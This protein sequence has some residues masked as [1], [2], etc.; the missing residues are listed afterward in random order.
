MKNKKK[1]NSQNSHR[2]WVLMI[3][4]PPF[5][6]YARRSK[7]AQIVVAFIIFSPTFGLRLIEYPSRCV[8]RDILIK[9]N[10]RQ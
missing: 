2:P 4:P 5:S 8:G 3:V 1:S 9:E 10:A 6:N 7:G